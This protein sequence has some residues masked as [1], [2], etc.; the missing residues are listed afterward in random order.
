MMGN[1]FFF[2]NYDKMFWD[3]NTCKVAK[4]REKYNF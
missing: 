2:F 3:A 4:M 1:C